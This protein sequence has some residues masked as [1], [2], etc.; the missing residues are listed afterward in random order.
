MYFAVEGLAEYAAAS[1]E[2]SVKAARDMA[3]AYAHTGQIGPEMF[4]GLIESAKRY[5]IV[6][7]QD[8]A[9]ANAELAKAFADPAKGAADLQARLGAFD[10]KTVQ[11][12][13]HLQA[14]GDRLGAQRVRVDRRQQIGE[15]RTGGSAAGFDRFGGALHF[16]RADVGCRWGDQIVRR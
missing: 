12:I 8:V 14:S 10:D 5:A 4:G 9:D 3:A 15:R 7:G 11:L 6:T 2:V 1:G 16:E 13:T